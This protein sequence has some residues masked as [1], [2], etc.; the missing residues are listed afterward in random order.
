MYHSLLALFV[1]G[2]V[3]SALALNHVAPGGR[4]R[5]LTDR[6]RVQ[7]VENG[8][9]I[10]NDGK[11]IYVKEPS[12]KMSQSPVHNSSLTE[13][14]RLPINGWYISLWTYAE[15]TYYYGVWTVPPIPTY[16]NGQILF[17]FNSLENSGGTDILQPVL[18]LNNGVAGWT[19][20]SWYG[21]PSGEYYESTPVAVSPGEQITGI[22]YL[23]GSTWVILGYVNGE[24]E[25][26]LEVALSTEGVQYN[27]EWVLE[28]YNVDTC[29][30]LPATNEIVE[31]DIILETSAGQVSPVWYYDIYDSDC[32]PSVAA[33]SN[34]AVLYWAA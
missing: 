33:N 3:A 4:N 2:L 10:V 25:T 21:T 24:L 28:V 15:Y 7:I 32:S 16:D 19:L 11:N 20:A 34:T 1:C 6:S 9:R 30:S 22:I 23:S 12:G 26:V 5:G 14:K 13:Q 17:F 29:T 31:S 18:Q 27:A 8:T